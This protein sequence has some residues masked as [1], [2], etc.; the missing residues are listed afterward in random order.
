MFFPKI[1]STIKLES[2][3]NLGVQSSSPGPFRHKNHTPQ[4]A[5]K[6]R[7]SG[8]VYPKKGREGLLKQKKAGVVLRTKGV[9]ENKAES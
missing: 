8:C 5:E 2:A 6:K 3:D 4:T 7:P 1:K 9:S